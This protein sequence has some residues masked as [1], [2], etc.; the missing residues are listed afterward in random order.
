MSL[1]EVY[2]VGGSG[3]RSASARTSSE[4]KGSRFLRRMFTTSVAVQPQRPISTN[5]IGLFAVFSLAASST[6]AWPLVAWPR[7]RSLSVHLAKAVIIVIFDLS[8]VIGLR[9]GMNQDAEQLRRSLLKANFQLGDHIVHLRQRQIVG[10]GYVTGKIQPPAHALDLNVMQ[11]KYFL[12]IP[13][14]S[15][16]PALEVAVLP[17]LIPRLNS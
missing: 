3:A 2:T 8:R 4:V 16:E 5:S 6:T 10:H 9:F 1:I 14:N 13:H 17:N 12:K 11:I 15:R 7:K